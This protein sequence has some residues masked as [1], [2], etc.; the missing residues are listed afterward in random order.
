MVTVHAEGARQAAK[1]IAQYD[2]SPVPGGAEEA[3]DIKWP[4]RIH[5]RTLSAGR[6]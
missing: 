4:E 5:M 6:G 2:V 3:F 1:R